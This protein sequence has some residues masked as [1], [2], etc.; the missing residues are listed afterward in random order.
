MRN[1][2]KTLTVLTAAAMLVMLSSLPILAQESDVTGK[3]H[4]RGDGDGICDGSGPEYF[5]PATVETL[6]GT[7]SIVYGLYVQ[8]GT[9]NNT[10]NGM[11]YLFTA[12]S[13]EKL[14]AMTGP[15]W[16]MESKGVELSEGERVT[17]TGS[18]V[19]AHGDVLTDHDYL[20]VTTLKADGATVALRSDDGVPLWA[21]DSKGGYYKS[22][23]YE[24]GKVVTVEGTVL[25]VRT[26]TNGANNDA[27]CELILR[28]RDQQKLRVFLGPQYYCEQQG[29]GLGAGDQVRLR[30]SVRNRDM[31][32]QQLTTANG[33]T[34]QF[35]SRNGSPLWQR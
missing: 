1:H 25:S 34:F 32:C 6:S 24:G 19:P 21:G 10:G 18:I 31:V 11:H 35:R 23:S 20:I 27:G 29:L 12:D 7:I 16:F 8:A 30:G 17:F 22:P 26:R 2:V 9:G 5:D 13:G 3:G 14:Y 4:G 33:D 15:F 28:T